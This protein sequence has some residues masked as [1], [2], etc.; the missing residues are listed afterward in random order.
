MC[1][2]HSKKSCD[3][4]NPYEVSQDKSKWAP[5]DSVVNYFIV[6]QVEVQ[7]CKL[8][9][10]LPIAIT[11]I[12]SNLAK[13]ICIAI[14]LFAF[15]NHAALVTIGDAVA[16]FLEHEDQETLGRCL[17]SR[18]EFEADW[19][20]KDANG[21]RSPRLQAKNM[22]YNPKRRKWIMGTSMERWVWTYAT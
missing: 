2:S 8:Q 7:N 14:T 10:C 16:S 18:H 3:L 15:K 1:A 6:E 13:A 5:Y 12:L 4:N 22:R 21:N 20:R 17:Y 19:N 11:V 9:Y